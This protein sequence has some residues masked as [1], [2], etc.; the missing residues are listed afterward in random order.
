MYPRIFSVL[1]GVFCCIE[2]MSGI[3]SVV[4]ESPFF[5][6]SVPAKLARNRK[7]FAFVVVTLG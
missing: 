6:P 4:K 3:F 7:P 1:Y 2:F 5:I